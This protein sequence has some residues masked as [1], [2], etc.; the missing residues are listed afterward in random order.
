MNQA[1]NRKLSA[2]H[3]LSIITKTGTTMARVEG[4]AFVRKSGTT[5][6][7]RA[8][9]AAGNGFGGEILDRADALLSDRT[10][11]SKPPSHSGFVAGC[12]AN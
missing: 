9:N 5:A 10:L 4:G 7:H 2:I 3:P 12:L 6:F 1:M 11:W 8:R